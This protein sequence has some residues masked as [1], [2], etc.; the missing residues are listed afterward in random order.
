[1]TLGSMRLP[2]CIFIRNDS[3]K[4]KG[5]RGENDIESGI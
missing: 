2:S 1:M 4:G 5:M 3:I